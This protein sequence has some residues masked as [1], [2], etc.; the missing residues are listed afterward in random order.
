MPNQGWIGDLLWISVL[1][2]LLAITG[3]LV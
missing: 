1:A 3:G 2:F